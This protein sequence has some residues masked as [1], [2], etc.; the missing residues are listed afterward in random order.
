MSFFNA[1]NPSWQ[2][3]SQRSAVK[4]QFFSRRQF[5]PTADQQ[6]MGTAFARLVLR[7]FFISAFVVFCPFLAAESCPFR[8]HST[9]T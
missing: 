6:Q 4:S 9:K 7:R 5:R 3:E 2:D 8:G 1:L